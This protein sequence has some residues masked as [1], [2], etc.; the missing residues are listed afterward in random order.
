MNFTQRGDRYA[1]EHPSIIFTALRVAL[2]L[3][4]LGLGIYFIQNTE[5]IF[6]MLHAS[7]SE[8]LA[9]SLAHYIALMHI[10]GGIMIAV[11]F[12][13]RV[14]I[15]FNLPIVIAALFVDS[16]P[17]GVLTGWF[18]ALVVLIGF[19]FFLFYGS[20]VHS[21][22]SKVREERRYIESRH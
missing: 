4:L 19:L 2:G 18:L 22:R 8:F 17:L 7:T 3:L 1:E 15:L 9:I 14:A 11:G 10:V 6:T 12:L 20:G 21:F 5:A 13:T 16:G